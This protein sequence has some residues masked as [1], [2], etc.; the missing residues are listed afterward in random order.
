MKTPIL[1][2]LITMMEEVVQ[3]S[4]P[5]YMDTIF[6]EPEAA[7]FAYD[8]STSTDMHNCGTACCIVGYAAFDSNVILAANVVN[9][10]SPGNVATDI[11]GQLELE[12]GVNF[13]DSIVA[14]DTEIRMSNAIRALNARYMP[15]EWLEEYPH[16]SAEHNTDDP[17]HAVDY[18][19]ELRERLST[20]TQN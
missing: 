19:K 7:Q 14:S 11:W 2:S 20:N 1:D 12:L 8:Q 17:Q 15:T 6:K 13:A 10:G 3:S 4:L 16:L 5:L 18:M 9:S